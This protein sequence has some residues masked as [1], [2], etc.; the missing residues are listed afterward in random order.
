MKLDIPY[1]SQFT[2]VTSDEWKDRSCIVVC[3]KMALDFLVP[4][5]APSVDRLIEEAL[6]HS[7]SMME[8][9]LITAKSATHGFVHDVIVV[10]AHNHG[11]PAYREEFKSLSLDEHNKPIPSPYVDLILQRG[12]EKLKQGIQSRHVPIVSVFPGLSE[13]ESFHTILL[14]GFEEKDG[15]VTGFYYND[16]DAKDEQRKDL[17]LELPDFLKYW[18]KMV[19]FVG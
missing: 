19:I 4:G 1:Y 16:P 8:H 13:G 9:G 3:L 5:K 7:A 6:L 12:I 14:T 11:V 15:V 17:F 2:E 10:L 18:R